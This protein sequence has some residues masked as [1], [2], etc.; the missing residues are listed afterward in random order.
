MPPSRVERLR[1]ILRLAMAALYIAAGALHLAA[2]HAFAVIVPPAVPFPGAVVVMTGV[3]EVAGAVGLAVP[4]TRRLAGLMLAIYAFCVWPAN[5]YQAFWHV[6]LW[7]VPDSWWY[8]APRIALQPVLV[9]WALFAGGLVSWPFGRAANK[10][11]P[12]NRPGR[13]RDRA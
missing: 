11:A 6:R 3:C 8:H 12:A 13:F 1:L 5:V 2:T 7:P 4:A 10:D 9:W